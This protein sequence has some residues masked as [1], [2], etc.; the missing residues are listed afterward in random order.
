MR[1]ITEEERLYA[2]DNPLLCPDCKNKLYP[3]SGC[4]YCPACGFTSCEQ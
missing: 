1:E 4:W 2:V 3:V